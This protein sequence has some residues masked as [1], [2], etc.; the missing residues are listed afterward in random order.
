MY[1]PKPVPPGLVVY[2]GSKIFARCALAIPLPVSR[3]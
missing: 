3:S 2:R 1:N